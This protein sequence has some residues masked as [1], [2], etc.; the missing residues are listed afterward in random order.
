MRFR[1]VYEDREIDED[2]KKEEAELKEVQG[3]WEA[4]PDAYHDDE[5]KDEAWLAR[6]TA[7]WPIKKTERNLD[8]P[9]HNIE[10]IESISRE[11]TA[12]LQEETVTQRD[13]FSRSLSDFRNRQEEN[14]PKEAKDKKPSSTSKKFL[15]DSKRAAFLKSLSVGSISPTT[16]PNSGNKEIR[17][18]SEQCK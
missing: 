5:D 2:R 7:L 11:G 14:Q 15:P 16:N 3:R 1:E 17:E 9:E 13:A 8:N 6:L 18:E 10:Q 4:N 12:A